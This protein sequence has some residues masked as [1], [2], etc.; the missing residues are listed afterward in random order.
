MQDFY[1]NTWAHL[2]DEVEKKKKFIEYMEKN[3]HEADS[4]EDLF[5]MA[6]LAAPAAAI[7]AK[8]SSESIPQVKMFKLHYIPDVVFVP[9]CTLF[10]IMGATAVHIHKSKKPTK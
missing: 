2:K 8:R 10:A 7:I 6:G 5:I 4:G 9:V 3:I 1:E